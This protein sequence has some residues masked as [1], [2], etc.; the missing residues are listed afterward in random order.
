MLFQIPF[1]YYLFVI[2][3]FIFISSGK[4]SFKNHMPMIFFLLTIFPGIINLMTHNI[5]NHQEIHFSALNFISHSDFFAA[6]SIYFLQLVLV[7]ILYKFFY[8]YSSIRI[9]QSKINE[10][11]EIISSYFLKRRIVLNA[12]IISA[13]CWFIGFYIRFILSDMDDFTAPVRANSVEEIRESSYGRSETLSGIFMMIPYFML[14]I[15][16]EFKK[17]TAA[18]LVFSFYIL[19]IISAGSKTGFIIPLFY[20]FAYLLIRKRIKFKLSYVFIII[21]LAIPSFALG[22][23]IRTELQGWSY[24]TEYNLFSWMP[25]MARRDTSIGQT[26]VM[27]ADPEI[28]A[29]FIL[30]YI[31]SF[32]GLA[33]PSFIWPDK[34]MAPGYEIAKIF[35]F[36]VQAAAPG[37]LGGLL[38]IF[39]PIG[40]ILSPLIVSFVLSQF[41]V[42]FSRASERISLKY[43]IIY[44]ILIDVINIFMDGQYHSLLPNIIILLL[45]ISIIF[46]FFGIFNNLIIKLPPTIT[47]LLNFFRR[48]I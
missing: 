17:Y 32:F 46:I 8:D 2:A 5:Y 9:G 7:V 39:G 37:W 13:I 29:Y 10:R 45:Q 23:L 18:L 36:G 20:I 30:D 33:V 41:S 27:I 26:A 19:E 48:E 16:I 42:Q 28:Y 4:I 43:P 6:Y 44:F 3:L 1:V 21:I 12:I 15:L 14:F 35:G 38:F 22:E 25:G 31:K 11:W 24:G 34:P 47:S 40:L